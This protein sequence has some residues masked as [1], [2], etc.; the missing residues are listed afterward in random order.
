M[1]LPLMHRDWLILHC[2][3]STSTFVGDE[4][5]RIP[6]TFDPRADASAIHTSS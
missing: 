1:V 6:L 4:T 3:V 2:Q 5:L